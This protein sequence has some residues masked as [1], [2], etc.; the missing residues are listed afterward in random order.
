MRPPGRPHVPSRQTVASCNGVP[1]PATA[2]E[3]RGH[4][5]NT[6][7]R[8]C[9]SQSVAQ[10]VW[11]SRELEVQVVNPCCNVDGASQSCK[12]AAD[13]RDERVQRAA[14]RL[15]TKLSRS[16]S[17]NLTRDADSDTRH[18]LIT[19][20]KAGRRITTVQ[21][22][23]DLRHIAVP[24]DKRAKTWPQTTAAASKDTKI[25]SPRDLPTK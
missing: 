10:W 14:R 4:I 21:E 16:K 19:S 23:V 1:F 3:R 24:T 17:E 13:T 22:P 15:L 25:M 2:T 12:I 18:V 11:W 5:R 20:A 6:Q 7:C 8:L 9:S